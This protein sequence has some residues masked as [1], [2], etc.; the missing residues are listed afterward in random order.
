MKIA[1]N[2]KMARKAKD[3]SQ[4]KTAEHMQTTREQISKYE[5]GVN[6]LT[7]QRL[8]ELCLLYGVSADWILG[9]PKGLKWL[10]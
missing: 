5:T 2:L 10:D 1:Q 9:L 3:M 8:R 4:A 6:D 7:A